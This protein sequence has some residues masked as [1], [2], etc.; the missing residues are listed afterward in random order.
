MATAIRE[1]LAASNGS[2][3]KEQIRAFIN[4]QYPGEWQDTTLTAHLYACAV[5][6]PRA[7][8]HHPYA[9]RFLFKDQNGQFH[10]YNENLHGPNTWVPTAGDDVDSAVADVIEASVSLERDVEEHLIQNLS[11]LEE[12][13]RFVAS[14]VNNEVGRVDIL[15]EDANGT[16]VIIELKVGEAKDAAIGQIARYLGWYAQQGPVRG[17][18]IASD[19]SRPVRFG[20]A[21]IPNLSLRRLRLQFLFEEISKGS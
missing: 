3:T 5:N 9:E 1:A 8:I 19:F 10:L 2:A 11:S 17:I 4:K 6:Q 20:A 13:L 12:G 14:Q 21:A 16:R 7:Y 18:L 15:A